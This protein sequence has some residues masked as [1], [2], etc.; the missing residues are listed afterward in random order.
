[1]KTIFLIGCG[2]MGKALVKGWLKSNLIKKIIIIEPNNQD[3]NDLKTDKIELIFY[4]SIKEISKFNII[5]VL[6]LAVKPQNI[7]NVLLE[8]K[9]LSDRI[10][11]IISIIAGIKINKYEK[12]LGKNIPIIR[13]MPNTPASVGEGITA[14]VGNKICN[15]NFFEYSQSILS[16]IGEVITLKKEFQIDAVTAVSGSGP[17]YFFY[18]VEALINAGTKL[19][20]ENELAY[21]LGISTF[22]GSGILAK[23][24]SENLIELRKSVT[25]P[26]G[27][28]EAGLKKLKENDKLF[29]LLEETVKSAHKRSLEIGKE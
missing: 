19:G 4:K 25:S 15:N 11:L 14:I 21:R 3:I 2:K 20:L 18:F 10:K 28:T 23:N 27:T 26:G 22:I 12:Y 17:A 6:I 16:G 5:D 13:A 29:K 9:P 1:M 24:L 8:L 7:D